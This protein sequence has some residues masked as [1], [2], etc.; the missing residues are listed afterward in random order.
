MTSLQRFRLRLCAIPSVNEALLAAT[1][2]PLFFAIACWKTPQLAGYLEGVGIHVSMWTIFLYG[3]SGYLF[4]L[5][6]HKALGRWYFNR[7]VPEID[8]YHQA[9]IAYRA[10]IAASMTDTPEFYR[11]AS[12][13]ERLRI[14]LGHFLE[15]KLFN[16][17]VG[18]LRRLLTTIRRLLGMVG[19]KW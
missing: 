3:L 15:P 18:Q 19:G 12:E 9:T 11:A 5:G 10:L 13:R 2:W 8:R 16:H 14:R 7:H 17:R 1:L 6:K 4:L